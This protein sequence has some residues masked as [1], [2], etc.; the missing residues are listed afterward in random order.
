LV[1]HSGWR[2]VI[3]HFVEGA[4]VAVK[5]IN[6]GADA[7]V[8]RLELVNRHPDAAPV[9]CSIVRSFG[10][11][12]DTGEIA[13]QP[14]FRQQ[15]E[16]VDR[17]TDFQIVE[18]LFVIWAAAIVV[19]VLGQKVDWSCLGLR[20]RVSPDHLWRLSEGAQEHATHVVAISKTRLPG[21]DIDRMAALLHH[22]LPRHGS[23]HLRA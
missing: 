11:K 3:S 13:D 16:P 1:H 6:V 21:D 12:H 10:F 15:I 18:R 22:Q 23:G 7:P 8:L 2:L 19:S 5:P 14:L 4:G 9:L 20:T 17:D